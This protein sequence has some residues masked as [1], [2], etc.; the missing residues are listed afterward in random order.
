MTTMIK[1][2][3]RHQVVHDVL[4]PLAQAD[5]ARQGAGR[6]THDVFNAVDDVSFTV[7]RGGVGRA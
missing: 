6:K 5:G 2:E 1:V 7:Q 3:Q 4:P